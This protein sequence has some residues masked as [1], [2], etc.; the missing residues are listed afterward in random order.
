MPRQLGL[1][2]AQ[3]E[4]QAKGTI[5]ED[6]K[7]YLHSA[8]MAGRSQCDLARHFGVSRH[9]IRNWLAKRGLQPVR[10]VHTH[11]PTTSRRKKGHRK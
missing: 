11:T 5:H 6:L 9:T 10:S 8:L 7:D 2:E 3:A 1:I 4:L